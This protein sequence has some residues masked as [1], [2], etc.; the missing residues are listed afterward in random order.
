VETTDA[1]GN[2]LWGVGTDP[3]IIS[4]SFRA[5]LAAYERH[6]NI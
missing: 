5:V 1:D 3:N 4:A 2:V 6:T